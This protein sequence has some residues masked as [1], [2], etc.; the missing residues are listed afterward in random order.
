MKKISDS[1]KDNNK[2]SPVRTLAMIVNKE[3]DRLLVKESV[4]DLIRTWGTFAATI[5]PVALSILSAILSFI[6]PKSV[7]QK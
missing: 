2:F 5:I 1:F 4:G 7:L 3:P 6:L